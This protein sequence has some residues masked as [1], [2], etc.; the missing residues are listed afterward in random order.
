MPTVAEGFE[1]VIVVKN[2]EEVAIVLNA[3][4]EFNPQDHTDPSLVLTDIRP[5]LPRSALIC[6]GDTPFTLAGEPFPTCIVY[7]IHSCRIAENP[8][9][10][11][12]VA[13]FTLPQCFCSTAFRGL[14]DLMAHIIDCLR[15]LGLSPRDSGQSGRS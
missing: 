5:K 9:D 8:T 13:S 14:R 2:D 11:L 15:V 10:N 3:W 4:Q 12:L 6:K 1:H 7:D